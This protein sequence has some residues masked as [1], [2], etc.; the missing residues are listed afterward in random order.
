MGIA[1]VPVDPFNPGQVFACLGLMELAEVLIGDVSAGFD[2]SSPG[3]T[4]FR[5]AAE[6]SDD[7]IQRGLEFLAQAEV[8]AR[9][10]AGSNYEM[11]NWGSLSED[12]LGAPFPIPAPEKPAPLPAVLSAKGVK[13]VLSSWG[14]ASLPGFVGG[15]RDNL[16]FW[17]GAGGYP[18]VALLRDSLD[19]CRDKL[20]QAASDPFA[21]QAP[22][23]SSFRFD[24][25][26][27]YIPI[28]AGFSLN[29]HDKSFQPVG[30]PL[31]EILAAVGLSHARPLRCTKLSYRYA[32]AG[33]SAKSEG[34]ELLPASFLRAILGTAPLPFPTRTFT[35]QLGW[36]GQ[37]GQARCITTVTEELQP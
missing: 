34:E 35:M 1:S 9:A 20:G 26:R 11:K 3:E 4:Q 17:G 18:A 10:P 37:Q 29:N 23:S 22:Q 2:W 33:R 32:F 8:Y 36:P 28:D 21:L 25:R 19:S 24:W 31:V 30:F 27:D 13:I 15:R 16:K 5:L 12:S 6:D 7:P 14:D